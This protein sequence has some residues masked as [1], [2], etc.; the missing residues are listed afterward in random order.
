MP[1]KFSSCFGYYRGTGNGYVYEMFGNTERFTVKLHKTKCE[2]QCLITVV[3]A[4]FFIYRVT[5]WTSFLSSDIPLIFSNSTVIS[6]L[7]VGLWVAAC[8]LQL[9]RQMGVIAQTPHFHE[10]VHHPQ[11]VPEIDNA[12]HGSP[13]LK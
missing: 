8:W 2:L 9:R 13:F 4:Q 7:S 12:Q 6:F 1:Y 5:N 10:A 3:S 11:P